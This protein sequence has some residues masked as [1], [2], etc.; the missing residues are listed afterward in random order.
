MAPLGIVSLATFCLLAFIC[1]CFYRRVNRKTD[2]VVETPNPGAGAN[3]AK[4]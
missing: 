4:I 1:E 2:M 3:S